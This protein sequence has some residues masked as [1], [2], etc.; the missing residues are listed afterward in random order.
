MN[1]NG[2]QKKGNFDKTKKITNRV[3]NVGTEASNFNPHF[4]PF[5]FPKFLIE[6]LPN[7]CFIFN[8]VAN[9]VQ[10]LQVKEI[11]KVC[12]LVVSSNHTPN[13]RC[14]GLVKSAC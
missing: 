5:C 14:S 7:K 8:M 12:R 3:E 9:F 10:N 4:S 2:L 11:V 6:V 13:K 1:N